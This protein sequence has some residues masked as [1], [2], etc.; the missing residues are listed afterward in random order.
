MLPA[1]QGLSSVL[2]DWRGFDAVL[3]S[4]CPSTADG[5]R[6]VL[7]MDNRGIGKSSVPAG[8]YTVERMARDV[9]AVAEAVLGVGVRFHVLGISMGGEHVRIVCER[10]RS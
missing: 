2:E 9:L 6:S 5:A 4:G 8:P 3:A 7:T 1:S 10:L